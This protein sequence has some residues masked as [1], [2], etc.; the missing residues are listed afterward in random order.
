MCVSRAIVLAV[1]VC[2]ATSLAAPSA[3]EE[4]AAAKATVVRLSQEKAVL[5]AELAKKQKRIDQLVQALKDNGMAVPPDGETQAQAAALF[6]PARAAGGVGKGPWVVR[7]VSNEEPSVRDL[8]QRVLSEQQ[9]IDDVDRQLRDAKERHH[10]LENR[11]EYYW[12]GSVRHRRRIAS[13]A[14]I[15]RSRADVSRLENDRRRAQQNLARAERGI[16]DAGKTRQV[17]AQTADGTTVELTPANEAAAALARGL[18]PG[19]WYEV[20]GH[21]TSEN[22]AVRVRMTGSVR[23][24]GPG[25]LGAAGRTVEG[26]ALER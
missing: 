15:Q 11:Y 1:V 26:P 23:H 10:E 21:G 5:K 17:V 12:N 14:Q 20:T 3:E 8:E 9:K 7:I 22:G 13:N 24:P 4:A 19:D 25:D 16:A 2:S 6:E 18:R